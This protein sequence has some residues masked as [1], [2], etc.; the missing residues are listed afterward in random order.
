M[1]RSILWY[2]CD[3]WHWNALVFLCNH[4]HT[5]ITSL[6]TFS[7]IWSHRK[8]SRWYKSN[9]ILFICCSNLT[10]LVPS[11]NLLEFLGI[12]HSSNLILGCGSNN[13]FLTTGISATYI[14]YSSIIVGYL[15]LC[16]WALFLGFASMSI[17]PNLVR[18]KNLFK[19]LS[20]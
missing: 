16:Q 14:R 7:L 2:I 5:I 17:N 4:L 11:S 13:I 20:C 6:V 8:F 10:Y 3:A 9:L 19:F 1:L 15:S 12:W 18:K